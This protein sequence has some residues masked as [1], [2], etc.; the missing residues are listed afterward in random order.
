LFVPIERP[1]PQHLRQPQPL[2]LPSVKDRLDD[3]RRETGERE[4]P[5]VTFMTLR[6]K[7]A[8]IAGRSFAVLGAA[9]AALIVAGLFSTCR[10]SIRPAAATTLCR[11]HRQA[12]RLQRAACH[13]HGNL[14]VKGRSAPSEPIWQP[15][16]VSGRSWRD[17]AS[18]HPSFSVS[19]LKLR[20]E[21][22]EQ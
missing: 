13:R 9:L 2:R 18:A 6:N 12:D 20:P 14:A 11:L 15:G 3:V 5:A 16:S 4:Q 10:L 21:A 17:I 7:A 1:I 19:R 22:P 8:R